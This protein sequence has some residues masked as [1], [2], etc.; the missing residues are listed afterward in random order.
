MKVAQLSGYCAEH[1]AYHH[2]EASLQSTIIG[3]AQDFVGSN[4]INL[5]V[6]SGQFG[7]R[8]T[9][10]TDAASPRYI[11]TQLADITRILFPEVDDSLL[12]YMEDDGQIIEPEYFA[13]IIPLLLVNGTNGIGTGWSSLI[14]QHS[15]RALVAYLKARLDEETKLPPIRPFVRG[16]TGAFDTSDTGGYQSVGRAR[17]S[18]RTSIL[19]DELPVGRWTEAQKN[20]LLKMREKDEI[21][22]FVENHTTT[23]VSFDITLDARQ[24]KKLEKKGLE[25]A[26]KL[27]SSHALSNMHAFDSRGKITKYETPEGIV[28]AFFPIRF[29][30]YE[31]RISVIRSEAEYK[32]LL[33]ENKSRFIENVVSGEIKLLGSK[34][35]KQSTMLRLD[36]L[37]FASSA[38]LE[39]VRRNNAL[40]E[41][42]KNLP[43]QETVDDDKRYDYL[44][45]M[46]LS[47]LTSEKMDDLQKESRKMKDDLEKVRDTTPREL[48][49]HD[50]DSLVPYLPNEN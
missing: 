24:V 3:M 13:P 29:G 42:Q 10:G 27:T 18:G 19:I 11:F 45:N 15:P 2:G 47:S 32:S 5:L 37:G 23:K 7:T 25:K 35:T 14:P 6:P 31:D 9:G 36:E 26:L 1:T 22:S 34:S 8:L 41:R 43:L 21:K 46:Q 50:L 4:N 39:S 12:C 20:I 16:F 44:L 30:L 17:A 48:W 28:D 40:L 38:H 49:H 33:L